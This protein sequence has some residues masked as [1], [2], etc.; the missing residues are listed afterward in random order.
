ML[1]WLNS[2]LSMEFQQVYFV[3]KFDGKM[4]NLYKDCYGR[5]YMAHSE[6]GVRCLTKNQTLK[7]I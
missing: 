7:I 4:V 2:R 6:Y 5:V 1:K 3:D